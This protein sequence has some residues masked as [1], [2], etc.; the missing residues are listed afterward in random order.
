[1]FEDQLSRMRR[2]KD[3]KG[4]L[5]RESFMN[6]PPMTPMTPIKTKSAFIGVI[7]GLNDSRAG[8]PLRSDQQ[9][10]SKFRG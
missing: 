5:M 1:M 8:N 7:G 9:E 2:F 6:R 10:G 4:C 3:G